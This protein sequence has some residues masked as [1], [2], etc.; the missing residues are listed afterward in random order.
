MISPTTVL[1]TG[2]AGYVG[3]KLV[4]RLL[5]LGYKVHVL[6]LYL[7]HREVFSN[8]ENDPNLVQ[9]VGDVR[10]TNMVARA[11]S[12]CDVLIHLACVSNDPSFELDPEL[13][14]SINYDAFL[15]LIHRAKSAGVRRFIYISSSSVYGIKNNQYVTEDLPLEPLTDYS[16]FKAMCEETLLKESEGNFTT[17]ILRPATVCGYAPRLRLDLTVNILTNHAVNR[18]SIT[19]YGGSQL[20]PNIHIDDIVDLYAFCISCPAKLIDRQIFNVGFENYSIMDIAK[21]VKSEVGKNVKIVQ[22]STND[23]RSYHISSRKIADVLEFVPKNS[24]ADAVN[25]L[26]WAFQKGLVSQPMKNSKYFNVKTFQDAKLS[27]SFNGAVV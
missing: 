19:V 1:V 26:V 9:F 25:E 16:K 10:D 5:E 20:R 13:G 21:I 27:K 23:L 4:P 17:L 3:S 11:A 2:G 18:G 24:V 12:G 15:P 8:F 22:S 6:D 7:F 14:K